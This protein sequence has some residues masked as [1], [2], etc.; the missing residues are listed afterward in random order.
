MSVIFDGLLKLCLCPKYA[1]AIYSVLL[2]TNKYPD[3]AQMTK[4]PVY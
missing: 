2:M 1:N 4:L 3:N